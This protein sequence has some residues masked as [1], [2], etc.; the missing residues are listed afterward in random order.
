MDQKVFLQTLL[1]GSFSMLGVKVPKSALKISCSNIMIF[2]KVLDQVLAFQS[3]LMA[4]KGADK[5]TEEQIYDQILRDIDF[6]RV[7][8]Y[9]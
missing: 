7:F 6:N 4:K 9:L 8:N 3:Q 1:K 5:M 2:F